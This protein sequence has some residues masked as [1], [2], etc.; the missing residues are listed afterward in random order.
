MFLRGDT[1]SPYLQSCFSYTRSYSEHPYIQAGYQATTKASIWKKVKDS[2]DDYFDSY[3]RDE[4][5]L[6]YIGS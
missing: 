6:F 1:S 2:G 5:N 4:N 3:S